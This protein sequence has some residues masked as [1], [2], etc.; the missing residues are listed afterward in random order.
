MP[1]GSIVQNIFIETK[2][3]VRIYRYF[4]DIKTHGSELRG[5]GGSTLRWPLDKRT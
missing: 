5:Q 4:S 2:A 1:K 3:L